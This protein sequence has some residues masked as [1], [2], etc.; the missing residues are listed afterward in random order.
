MKPEE[1]MARCHNPDWDDYSRKLID[2]ILDH[3][4]LA[5][6]PMIAT[7]EAVLSVAGTIVAMDGVKDS[8]MQEASVI[9]LNNAIETAREGIALGV[10]RRH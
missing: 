6:A 4:K 9:Y 2:M 8:P 10:G 1:I 5:K 3:A 7:L